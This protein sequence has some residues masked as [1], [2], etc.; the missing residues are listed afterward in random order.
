[1]AEEKVVNIKNIIVEQF[2]GMRRFSPSIHS[3]IVIQEKVIEGKAE[4]R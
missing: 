2:Y 3:A 4:V 1:M